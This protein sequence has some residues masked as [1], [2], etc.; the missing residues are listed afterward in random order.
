MSGA[1]PR[2]FVVIIVLVLMAGCDPGMRI[3]Q[4]VP[5][6]RGAT[7]SP[8]M[9]RLNT[10]DTFIGSKVYAPDVE[11]VNSSESRITVVRVELVAQQ[12]T[13]E[14]NPLRAETFPI[15]VLSRSVQSLDVRFD[16]ASTVKRTF[17]HPAELRVHYWIDGK[18]ATATATVMAG[19]S[20]D[21]R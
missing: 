19:R 5:Q 21:S 15:D 3:H 13:F 8:I 11:I 17:G 10:S 2:A 20:N 16:L 7:K 18:E 6:Q 1:V 9:I 14:N 12:Q 4:D